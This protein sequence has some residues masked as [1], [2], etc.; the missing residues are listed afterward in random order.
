MSSAPCVAM[1]D[2]E[3]DGGGGKMAAMERK[4]EA[5]P[6]P[7]QPPALAPTQQ[8]HAPTAAPTT[9]GT[10]DSHHIVAVAP[11]APPA[12][13][14]AVAAYNFYS[15]RLPRFYPPAV[16]SPYNA[17]PA[18]YPLYPKQPYGVPLSPSAG[19]HSA[20]A[21]IVSADQPFA[22]TDAAT[23][24]GSARA[25]NNKSKKS[26]RSRKAATSRASHT[27]STTA[28]NHNGTA[29][30]EEDESESSDDSDDEEEEEE[31]QPASRRQSLAFAQQPTTAAHVGPHAVQPHTSTEPGQTNSR[32]AAVLAAVAVAGT[33]VAATPAGLRHN[34][35]S[36]N[37]SN[38]HDNDNKGSAVSMQQHTYPAVQHYPTMLPT[39]H[40]YYQAAMTQQH[41]VTAAHHVSNPHAVRAPHISPLLHPTGHGEAVGES[42]AWEH[43]GDDAY[44]EQ[45]SVGELY[46]L[47]TAASVQQQQYAY[48]HHPYF[49]HQPHTEKQPPHSQEHTHAPAAAG[50]QPRF[51]VTTEGSPPHLTI[52]AAGPA[53]S[54]NLRSPP[55]LHPSPHQQQLAVTSPSSQRAAATDLYQVGLQSPQSASSMSVSRTTQASPLSATSDL[56]DD[57]DEAS[58]VHINASLPTY[59]SQYQ[60]VHHAHKM[61]RSVDDFDVHL[62]NHPQEDADGQQ[63]LAP[64]LGESQ[65]HFHFAHPRTASD[66]LTYALQSLQLQPLHQQQHQQAPTQHE[67]QY[68]MVGYGDAGGDDVAPGGIGHS[69]RAPVEYQHYHGA[70]GRIFRVRDITSSYAEGEDSRRGSRRSSYTVHASPTTHAAYSHFMP[71]SPQRYPAHPYVDNTSGQPWEYAAVDAYHNAHA[72]PPAPLLSAHPAHAFHRLS[73]APSASKK[74]KKHRKDEIHF[75]DLRFMG[76]IGEGSFG[77][78]FRGSLWGQEVAI[79]KL[80]IQAVDGAAVSKEFKKEVKIMRTLRHPN[81]VE[82]LGVCMEPPNLCLVTEYLS[83]GSLED[84]L[85]RIA[86]NN[87]KTEDVGYCFGHGQEGTLFKKFSLKRIISLAKDIARGLNWLHHKGIIHRD[88][89]VT[90]RQHTSAHLLL[91]SPLVDSLS[92]VRSMCCICVLF[93]SVSLECQHSVGREW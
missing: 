57:A 63:H 43:A 26:R 6:Y 36:N 19:S 79:K 89:K 68:E 24:A 37:H 92:S 49:Y 64:Q 14:S 70:K 7:P 77:E 20:H 62:H 29:G 8:P 30:G 17:Y 88:L 27:T 91:P 41:T 51:A 38:N 58:Q 59:S 85:T 23:E 80:R 61:T 65:Q 47:P 34:N 75:A 31:G 74:T 42:V 56:P 4:E 72:V 10:G 35:H 54:S 83:N 9:A 66:D 28:A 1:A 93:L 53:G 82:F 78:V 86:A 5:Q 44:D 40:P 33:T 32:T 39:Y 48:Q 46:T 11:S 73:T 45:S 25:P 52:V 12:A 16:P 50:V 18:F 71:D 3:D 69:V 13:Q 60:H 2:E 55:V 67:Q 84:V 15:P 87:G 76:K 81:I 22:Y 21:H 90:A